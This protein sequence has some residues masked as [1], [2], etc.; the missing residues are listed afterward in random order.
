MPHMITIDLLFLVDFSCCRCPA[1]FRWS[2]QDSIDHGS[3]N[4]K[5]HLVAMQS[6]A[7]QYATLTFQTKPSLN[8][9][10][11]LNDT[12]PVKEYSGKIL[13]SFSQHF[14]FPPRRKCWAKS[15]QKT[16]QNP[17]R[18]WGEVVGNILYSARPPKSKWSM[19]SFKSATREYLWFYKEKCSEK[20]LR[21]SLPTPSWAGSSKIA[22]EY[23][24]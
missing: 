5:K 13:Q 6:L 15:A 8:A 14:L 10:P 4:T 1:R 12:R 16:L 2:W 18:S 7:V 23:L 9:E 20:V 24:K 19:M 22:N 21:T 3:Q 17:S 11:I